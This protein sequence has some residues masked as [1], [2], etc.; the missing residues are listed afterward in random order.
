MVRGAAVWCASAAAAWLR[1]G[2]E[3]REAERCGQLRGYLNQILRRFTRATTAVQK[4]SEVQTE[5][6]EQE[7]I[8]W[9]RVRGM[10]FFAKSIIQ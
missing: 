10:G 8:C 4:A 3:W 1:G 5:K 7:T 2:S 6:A 9:V